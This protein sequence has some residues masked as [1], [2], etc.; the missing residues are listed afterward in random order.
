MAC[1]GADEV[2]LNHLTVVGGQTWMNI[3]IQSC[4]V[5]FVA[6]QTNL[7]V[8]DEGR[9]LVSAGQTNLTVAVGHDLT[10]CDEGRDLVSAGQTNLTVAVGHDLTVGDEGCDLVV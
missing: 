3:R 6:G 2:G 8:G 7:T 9:D 10:V 4:C 1:P 5:E